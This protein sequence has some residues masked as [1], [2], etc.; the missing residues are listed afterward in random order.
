V[1]GE[2]PEYLDPLDGAGWRRMILDYAAPDSRARAAQRARL[3]RWSPPRWDAHFSAV[4]A[5]LD[6]IA[7][8]HA[9]QPSAQPPRRA[10]PAPALTVPEPL[11]AEPAI[12]R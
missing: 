6:G 12:L 10:A 1:G 4:D 7:A 11:A 5:L 8:R 3:R 2:V 9:G